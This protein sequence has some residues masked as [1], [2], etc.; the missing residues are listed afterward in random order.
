[1]SGSQYK[2][3]SDVAGTT[4]LSKVLC[5]VGC[6]IKMFSLFFCLLFMCYLCEK[7]YKPI[8][9][10]YYVADCVTWGPRLAL[11]D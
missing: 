3:R 10:Q 4:V 5:K 1:M 11:L 8:S 2:S 7:Y 6:K 9:V